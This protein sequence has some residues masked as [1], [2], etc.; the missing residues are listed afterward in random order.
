MSLLWGKGTV[1]G[2]T[3]LSGLVAS[4]NKGGPASGSREGSMNSVGHGLVLKKGVWMKRG[5]ESIH[6]RYSR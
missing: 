6:A 3:V 5:Y 1:L 4:S 2:S